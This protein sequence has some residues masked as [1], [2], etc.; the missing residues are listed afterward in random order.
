MLKLAMINMMLTLPATSSVE[1]RDCLAV[2]DRVD[3]TTV[4]L[5]IDDQPLDRLVEELE[6]QLPCGLRVDVAALKT[7]GLRV[8]ARLSMRVN[9]SAAL[10]A[11]AGLAQY[12]G[13]E[14]HRP[15]VEVFGGEMVIT[16]AEAAAGMRF[17]EVY[18]VR[19]LLAQDEATRAALENPP[20]TQKTDAVEQEDEVLPAEQTPGPA[21]A[22][23]DR[24]AADDSQAKPAEVGAEPPPRDA[25]TQLTMLLSNHVD[26]DDWI[27]FG[28]DCIEFDAHGTA[29]V[30]TA[31]AT[32]HRKFA[33]VLSKL[34]A[35]N[36][37]ALAIEA[38]IIELP[39]A[40]FARLSSRHELSSPTL[41]RSLCESKESTIRWQTQGLVAIGQTLA[42][43]SASQ[44]GH[45]ASDATLEIVPSIDR[46]SGALM[47]RI[48]AGWSDGGGRCLVQTSAPIPPAPAIGAAVVE[49]PQDAPSPDGIARLLTVVIRRAG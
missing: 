3:A 32:T 15:R 12:I 18:E 36:P 47:I 24:K 8:P 48:D 33:A 4:R 7:A 41:A 14:H 11:L 6:P 43:Q 1:L 20:P 29:I 49:F 40:T 31:P 19:D 28:G 45:G 23:P 22:A 39:R 34:R 25:V 42:A 13:D 10:A 27:R 26:P 2:L 38:A 37:T 21:D 16:S 46:D 35:A 5:E 17:T 44:A 9:G 30:L